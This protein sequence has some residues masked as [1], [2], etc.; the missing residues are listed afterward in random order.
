MFEQGQKVCSK[1]CGQCL[2]SRDKIVS[3][4]RAKEALQQ[5]EQ[6]Q[7]HFVCHKGTAAGINLVCRGFFDNKTTPYL[8]LM[9]AT[10]K[11]IFADPV[12]LTQEVKNAKQR[13]HNTRKRKA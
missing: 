6:E 11:I 1:Q 7:T 3:A 8:E 12:S 5:C 13:S 4:E 2:F 9:K 10:D